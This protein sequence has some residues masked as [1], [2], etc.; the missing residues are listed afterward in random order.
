MLVAQIIEK[1]GFS[2]QCVNFHCWT[3][4]NLKYLCSISTIGNNGTNFKKCTGMTNPV[5][6]SLRVLSM[7][8]VILILNFVPLAIV[9]TE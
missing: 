3:Y 2:F 6:N 5:E 8:T 4:D 1:E 7:S 9:E